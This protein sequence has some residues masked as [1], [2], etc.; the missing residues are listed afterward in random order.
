MNILPWHKKKFL[1]NQETLVKKSLIENCGLGRFINIDK[2]KNDIL[3]E[4][5]II[6]VYSLEIFKENKVIIIKSIKELIYLIKKF[7]ECE[8]NNILEQLG[9]FL[10]SPDQN[11]LYLLSSSCYVNHSFN[12]NIDTIIKDNKW[13]LK[14]TKDLKKGEEL[15]A[16]YTSIKLP[17]NFQIFFQKK[18]IST[19]NDL[20][21]FLNK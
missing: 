13:I 20:L 14:V 1:K 7:K 2:K 10:H 18:K 4:Q 12:S 3:F 21:I 17:H 8:D 19:I 15:Y 9:N 5:S 11:N 6:D 16:D